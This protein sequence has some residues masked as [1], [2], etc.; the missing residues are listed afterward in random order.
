[1]AIENLPVQI[2]GVNPHWMEET[3]IHHPYFQD[4][5]IKSKSKS[6]SPSPKRSRARPRSIN[7]ISIC[8]FNLIFINLPWQW[9]FFF[10]LGTKVKWWFFIY[11]KITG[12]SRS[13]RLITPMRRK[14]GDEWI[15]RIQSWE[16]EGKTLTNHHLRVIQH[17]ASNIHPGGI[18]CWHLALCILALFYLKIVYDKIFRIF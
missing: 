1:M 2:Q 12:G 14:G 5:K 15:G 16:T 13:N 10:C 3:F 6:L 9:K 4:F 17:P 18:C 7:C 11:H 8:I